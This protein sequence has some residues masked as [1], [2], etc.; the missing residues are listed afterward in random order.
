MIKSS[1]VYALKIPRKYMYFQIVM[2]LPL[3]TTGFGGTSNS[4][5]YYS[6]REV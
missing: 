2:A 6:H 4:N 1:F 5:Y 3:I